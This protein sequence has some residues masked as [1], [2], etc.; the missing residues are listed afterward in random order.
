MV[1]VP[2]DAPPQIRG[3]ALRR[4]LIAG[5]R[6]VI[7]Q[8]EQL[9]RINVFPV[10]DGDTGS[11]LASTLGGVLAGALSRRTRD[12]GELLRRVGEDAVDGARGNSG[13]IMAQFLV[14]LAEQAR[15]LRDALSRAIERIENNEFTSPLFTDP[16]IESLNC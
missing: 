10:P 6:R 16:S 5:A 4:A 9:D 8:R 11:N 1:A 2:T 15:E 14:G 7:A 12:A 3:P 13:A